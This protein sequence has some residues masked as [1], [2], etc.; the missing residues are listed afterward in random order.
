MTDNT[1][2]TTPSEPQAEEQSLDDFAADFFSGNSVT[3]EPEEPANSEGAPTEEGTQ[4]AS[5][6]EETDGD[7]G[8]QGTP[9]PEATG[10]EAEAVDGP[11][12][13]EAKPG[14]NEPKAK[15]NSAQERIQELNAKFREAERRALEAERKLAEKEKAEGSPEEK[16][17]QEAKTFD[18][19]VDPE[20]LDEHGNR[21][22]PLGEFDPKYL[23]AVV[24]EAL[25]NDRAERDAKSQQDEQQRAVDAA[26][27]ALNDSWRAKVEVGLETMPDFVEK[28]ESMDTVFENVDPNYGEYLGRTIMQMDD[29]P[30]VLYHLAENIDEAQRIVDAGPVKA[31]IELAKLEAR[32]ASDAST[33]SGPTPK[34]SSA[35]TPPPVNKGSGVVKQAIDPMKTDNLDDFSKEFFKK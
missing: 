4:E 25:E 26:T 14:E 9:A 6:T 12:E 30:Q 19:S 22:Y 2:E 1:T 5:S 34:V 32:L 28:V 16:K 27:E 3:P 20:A 15:K 21:K 13:A 10:E 33:S 24:Q 18:S 29:G 23:Q 31:T 35:P 11:G 8:E 17:E 7:S